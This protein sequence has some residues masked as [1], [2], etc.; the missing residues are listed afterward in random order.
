MKRTL[1][2]KLGTIGLLAL[3]LLIPLTM[4]DGLVQERQYLRKSV[5]EDIARSSSQPQ[6]LLGP[7]LV[8]PWEHTRLVWRTVKETGV[9]YQE[10]VREY[11][12]LYFAP[13]RFVLDGQ[14]D[15][16]LRQRGIYEARLYSGQHRI[17]GHF[18][19]PQ[20]LGLGEQASEYRLGTPFLV[21]GIS[22]VRGIRN[23]PQLQL[24]GQSIA[25]RPG[26]N[27][28]LAAS[29]IHA[30]LPPLQAGSARRL[31]FSFELQLQGTSTLSL[32][33]VGR[34]SQVQLSSSW[35]HPSFTGSF[36]PVAREIGEDGFRA[37]WQ[38]SVFATSF[39]ERLRAC[40]ESAPRCDSLE[41]GAFGVSFID[42]VDQYLQS[43]RAI[44]YA[45]LFIALT[46]AGF[47]LCEVLARLAIHPVQ[48]SLVGLALA[49]FYLLLLSLAEH[50]AFA[51]AYLLAATACVSLL[52]LY[53][54]HLLGRRRAAAFAGGLA[55]LYA[56]L[57]GLLGSE[58]YALL[59]GSLLVFAL[60]A[61]F[62]L[63][64]R[65]LDWHAVGRSAAAVSAP[66][67]GEPA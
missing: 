25:F 63:L 59:M 61:A 5:L 37:R 15:T 65:K 49:L 40:Q 26:S 43:E 58:D 27:G 2:W 18:Q 11:G 23:A 66:D 46:F 16:E 64:T 41:A 34:D 62:M 39:D 36:L 6:Q 55:L 12:R 60:L 4:I 7:L 52:G 1:A 45:L 33:P 44:K 42:P 31:E 28:H 47:F 14:I 9:R 17:H 67:A 50:L 3:L 19:L 21:V 30:L 24:D 54:P 56:L 8:L 32:V 20:D 51:L 10:E 29:G 13:E 22:D 35:Q 53:L 48:Y 57:Y 38:T